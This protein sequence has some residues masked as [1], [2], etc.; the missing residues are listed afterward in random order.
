M[1]CPGWSHLRCLQGID[2]ESLHVGGQRFEDP[3]W[4]QPHSMSAPC[5]AQGST[6][7][8]CAVQLALKAKIRSDRGGRKAVCGLASWGYL[9]SWNCFVELGE[10]GEFCSEN[11]LAEGSVSGLRVAETSFNSREGARAGRHGQTPCIPPDCSTP[12]VV[13]PLWSSLLSPGNAS[14]KYH[15]SLTEPTCPHCRAEG[16][17]GQLQASL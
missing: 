4:G 3:G 15:L 14:H 2:G 8:F 12:A 11:C 9:S 6:I 5:W 1:H 17:H 7:H 10:E 13:S 16:S